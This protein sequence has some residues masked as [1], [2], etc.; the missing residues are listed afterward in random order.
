VTCRLAESNVARTV[1]AQSV[2][3]ELRDRYQSQLAALLS[4][5]VNKVIFD[6]AMTEPAPNQPYVPYEFTS[7]ERVGEK[8]MW[9]RFHTVDHSVLDLVIRLS[10]QAAH[11]QQELSGLHVV[12]AALTEEVELIKA[13]VLLGEAIIILDNIVADYVFGPYGCQGRPRGRI[14]ISHIADM[15]LYHELTPECLSRWRRIASL[16]DRH[17]WTVSDV[18]NVG[19]TLQD[20]RYQ[21]AHLPNDARNVSAVS[22]LPVHAAAS[23]YAAVNMHVG[24][25]ACRGGSDHH[26]YTAF[27]TC[28]VSYSIS[29]SE[30]G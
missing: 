1:P 3:S 25:L 4:I 27:T 5:P 13:Q 17:R 26:G 2:I 24:A 15:E 28:L 30:S 19:Q 20:I 23:M 8:R 14:S 18:R 12:A 9:F 22:V 6:G 10:S 7:S 11:L 21:P 16:W 29:E